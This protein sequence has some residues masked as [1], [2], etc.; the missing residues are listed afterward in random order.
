V[1]GG[2]LLPISAH[3]A[4]YPRPLGLLSDS[5]QAGEASTPRL[6]RFA[7]ML[8]YEVHYFFHPRRDHI[9]TINVCRL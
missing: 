4:C 7:A 9:G 2:Q 1:K 5:E 8:R 6:G 3:N